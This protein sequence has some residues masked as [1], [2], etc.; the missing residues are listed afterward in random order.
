[1]E[2]I[3]FI[4]PTIG[5]STLQQ[6]L[7]C[8]LQQTNPFWKAIIVF[9]GI[10]PTI[11]KSDNRITILKHKKLGVANYAGAV[12]NYGIL[13][14]TTEWV[15]FVDDDDGIKNTYVATFY[16]EIKYCSD[17]IVFRM[18]FNGN[19]L[20]PIQCNNF[21]KGQVGISFAVKKCLFDNGILFEPSEYEDFYY[22]DKC[23]AKKYRILISPY[24]LYFVRN[25]NTHSNVVSNRVFIK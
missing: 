2:K 20:P 11:Q 25:Y 14:A 1:M 10:E 21:Y 17:I 5:R 22:L 7:Q 13:H 16:Q 19:I 23:R 6:T 9:D 3:T 8:L 12:R 4:I 18:N 24:L 15:A